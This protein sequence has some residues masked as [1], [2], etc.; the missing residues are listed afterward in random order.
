MSSY[1]LLRNNKESGPFTIEEIK[2]MPLKA[3]DLIWVAGK[4]AAWRY[5]A[6]IPEL[7]SFAPAVPEQAVEAGFKKN[8]TENALSGHSPAGKP[9]SSNSRS[10]E[11]SSQRLIPAG[12]VYVNL[13]HDKKA[14]AVSHN[15]VV[16]E[17]NQE[18]EYKPEPV[19]DYTD[20]YKRKPSHSVQFSGRVLLI[21]TIVLF[22]VAGILTGL[23]IS[24]R[25]K[26]FSV[27]ASRT[28]SGPVIKPAPVNQQKVNSTT[29]NPDNQLTIIYPDSIKTINPASKKLT[30]GAKKNLKNSGVK[31]D[32]VLN[33]DASYTAL[34]LVDS[35]LKQN[36]ISK[37]EILYQKIKAH[38]ED[39]VDLVTGH[40]S[41]G[42]FGGISS[43]SVSIKNNSPVILDLVVVNIQ[44][45]Q[46]NDK[47]YKTESLSFNDLEPGETVSLKAPK[48]SRGIKISTR[49]HIVNSRKLDLSYSN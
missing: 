32:T 2:G 10:G 7:K 4:S 45:I 40:Y 36:T 19:Y 22:F 37:D 18:Q 35:T 44:Y 28:Q 34:K 42:V 1:L 3:F 12:S 11:N 29:L 14:A 24:D 30:G 49:I 26:F 25:R 27:D 47:I 21:S 38:P 16:S 6:E 48:S 8:N 5:P 13:P 31:K 9:G 43:F 20:L 23:F 46:N 17:P 39:Y 41:T 33:Q 15:R